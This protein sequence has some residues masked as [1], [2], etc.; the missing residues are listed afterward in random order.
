LIAPISPEAARLYAIRAQ[1]ELYAETCLKVA[2]KSGMLVPF[3][4]NRAQ[5]YLQAMIED[6]LER[7]GKVRIICLKGRQQGIS[8]FI[9]GRF[10]WKASGEFGKRFVIMTHLDEATSNLFDMVKR[11]HD[12]VPDAVKPK[13]RYDNAKE[14]AFATL[15]TKYTV[16]TA[17]SRGTGRSATAQYLHGSEVAYWTNAEKHMAGIG[18]IIPDEPGTEIVLEST[19]NG[20]GNLFHRMTMDAIKGKG[21]YE[22]VFIPW[23]WEEPYRRPLPAAGV[24]FDSDEIEYQEAFGIDDEQLYWRRMKIINDFNNDSTW[25]DAEYPATIIMAFLAGTSRALIPP[26]AVARVL[27]NS[28]IKDTDP[29]ALI[30]GVDPAE[31]G[32]DSTAAVLRRGRK[33][34][35]TW[36]WNGEGNAQ[37]AGRIGL[38]LQHQI[39]AK[40]PIDACCI[41]VTGIGTG[42][43]AILTDQRFRNIYRVHNGNKA[44]EDE[45]YRNRGAETWAR[46]ADWFKDTDRQ[47]SLPLDSWVDGKLVKGD[48]VLQAELSSR[49]YHYDAR[50]RLVLQ[51]KEE[52]ATKGID[53]PNMADALA[54]TFATNVRALK[55]RKVETLQDKLRRLKTRHSGGGSQG[56]AS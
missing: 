1:F 30:L 20:L 19:A 54:L 6:Q 56:M 13:V 37:I 5:R 24:D 18:Q 3:K 23:Y 46:M 2:T 51:S 35:T 7:T 12:N 42:V 49:N 33:V 22:L 14:L 16:S 45:K 43:E 50:R 8:T 44:I 48:T 38:I 17:G 32:T 34:I 26:L 21:D 15:Q 40:D 31:Y 11:Y 25:F 47:A 55:P 27:A 4:L 52:M 39:D 28:G 36:R 29:D 41:D 53:S 9:G 10:Y